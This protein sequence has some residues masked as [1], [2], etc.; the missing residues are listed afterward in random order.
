MESRL[1]CLKKL[2]T[3]LTE[4]NNGMDGCF[5]KQQYDALTWAIK[6]IEKV[7]K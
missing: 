7:R 3:K 6:E 4:P 5:D 2:A 1:K